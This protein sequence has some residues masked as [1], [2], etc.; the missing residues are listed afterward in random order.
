MSGFQV[1]V[2]AGFFEGFGCGGA[3]GG[4]H[5]MVQPFTDGPDPRAPRL[6]TYNDSFTGPMVQFL[7]PNFSHAT[8]FWNPITEIIDPAPVKAARPDIVI[9][10]FVERKLHDPIP[11]DPPEIRSEVIP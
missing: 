4:D 5:G 7:A 11:V 8:Y 2:N 6:L 3:D 10:E 1:G 9:H